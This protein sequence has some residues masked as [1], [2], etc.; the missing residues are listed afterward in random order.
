MKR[1][2]IIWASM[3]IGAM[4]MPLFS[5]ANNNGE[6]IKDIT[7]EITS[8]TYTVEIGS[9]LQLSAEVKNSTNTD[10]KWSSSETSIATIGETTGLVTGV[11]AGKTTITA[12]SVA[13]ESKKANVEISV[14]EAAKE[15]LISITT[16]VTEV[17]VGKTIELTA[18]VTGAEETGVIWSTADQTI[19]SVSETGVVTGLKEG[20]TEVIAKA[21]ADETKT[22]RVEI[23]VSSRTPDSVKIS[24]YTETQIRSHSTLQLSATAAPEIAVQTVNWSSSDENIATVSETGLVTFIGEGEVKITAASTKSESVKD[25][26]TFNPY[27]I[28]STWWGNESWDFSGL[29]GMEPTF[30]SNNANINQNAVINNVQGKYYVLEATAKVTDPSSSDVW[31]R[32]GLGHIPTTEGGRIHSMMVS[33]GINFSQRK[34]VVMDVVNGGVQWG[35]TTDR[36]QV[37]GQ[38][39]QSEFDYNNLKLTSVRNGNDYYYF[40]NEELYWVEKGYMDF[41]ETDTFPAFHAGNLNVEWSKISIKVGN[42]EVNNYLSSNPT[43]DRVYYP[44][45]KANVLCDYDKGVYKFINAENNVTTN[46]KDQ[47]IKA[48]G[49]ALILPDKVTSKVEFDLTIDLIG[50]RDA[51]PA[52]VATMNRYSSEP[53]EA[54]S[55]VIGENKA[56]FTGWNSNGDLNNGIGDGG[57]DYAT[58]LVE[59][60]TYHVEFYKISSDSVGIEN[61]IVVNG[62]DRSWWAD[63]YHGEHN[64]WF[65]VRDMNATIKNI[66]VTTVE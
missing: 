10:V 57:Q 62:V 11:A 54:R 61:R 1:T 9:T 16:T 24:G 34:T 49:S 31:S 15:V 53:W 60:E 19:A 65:G 43:S 14:T 4:S 21:K 41:A 20:K 56:G 47:A 45:Y 29:H 66:K 52:F 6:E 22:A 42:E 35:V 8:T 46:V 28:V 50:S 44:T 30:K 25:E 3:M 33:P 17:E 63:S 7:I 64:I 39:D 59:G 40:I 12:T 58:P 26:V 27:Y 23:A 55:A 36:S 13:D 32:I 5:C 51:T 18:A 37:W 2:R 38:H 48:M